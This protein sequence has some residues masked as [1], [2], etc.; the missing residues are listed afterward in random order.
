MKII[1]EE[2]KE[3]TDFMS[4]FDHPENYRE[5]RRNLSGFSQRQEII[6][7]VQPTEQR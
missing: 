3:K 6:L 1:K 2:R 4:K 7:K 5:V